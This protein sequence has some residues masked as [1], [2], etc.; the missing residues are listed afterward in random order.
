MASALV[1]MTATVPADIAARIEAQARREGR[2]PEEELSHQ[3]TVVEM[4]FLTDD[5]Q[6]Q[7]DR[8]AAEYRARQ[9]QRKCNAE[10]R[11]DCRTPA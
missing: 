8:D 3:L 5:E 7:E 4:L 2:S 11:V 9:Q 6:E 1:V 10:T